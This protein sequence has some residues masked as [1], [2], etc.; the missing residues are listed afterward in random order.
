MASYKTPEVRLIDALP[1]TGTGK[2]RKDD[3][4][5]LLKAQ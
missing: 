3:L 2:V 4:V 5:R 1:L